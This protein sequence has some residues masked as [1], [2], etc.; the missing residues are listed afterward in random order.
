MMTACVLVADRWPTQSLVLALPIA[1]SVQQR[2]R[3]DRMLVGVSIALLPFVLILPLTLDAADSVRVAG[4]IA[5][6]SLSMMLIAQ[7]LF[8]SG[9]MHEIVLAWKLPGVL[10]KM[11][12]L[13][14]LTVRCIAA[15]SEQSRT[16]QNA[17]R[18]RGFRARTSLRTWETFGGLVRQ[19]LRR[20]DARGRRATLAMQTRGW[21]GRWPS[22]RVYAFG[23]RDRRLILAV[24][25]VLLTIVSVECSA[26]KESP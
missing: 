6:R 13:A 2:L 17:V 19:M 20:A 25:A 7:I 8:A 10:G 24:F 1:A 22:L 9:P 18:M 16:V 23:F 12:S 4:A 5:F 21:A 26:A 11:Q 15:M 14:L 3:L